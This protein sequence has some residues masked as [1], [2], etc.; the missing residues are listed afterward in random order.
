VKLLPENP[1]DWWMSLLRCGLVVAAI[2]A[3]VALTTSMPGRSYAGALGP[4]TPE[5][6]RLSANLRAHIEQ[7]AGAIGERNTVRYKALQ[8]SAQYVQANLRNAGYQVVSQEF[9][10]DGSTVRNLIVEIPGGTRRSEIIVVGA[11]YD[12]VCSCP[13][14]DDNTSDTAA[15][16]ELARLFEVGLS[17]PYPSSRSIRQRG[18]AILSNEEHG[19]LGLREASTGC[20]R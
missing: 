11:H 3:F 8:A 5:Q 12:T 7:T 6:V 2:G 16:L 1:R 14:A 17:G 4:L 20:T 15:L 13:S 9:V 19:Q 18:A 10:A